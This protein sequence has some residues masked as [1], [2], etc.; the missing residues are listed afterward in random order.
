MAVTDRRAAERS[1]AALSF[2]F[3]VAG[4][5]GM[6]DPRE[7]RFQMTEQ[8]NAEGDREQSGNVIEGARRDA[9]AHPYGILIV[10]DEEAILE[11]LELTLGTD[12]RIFTAT[13]GAQG[14]EVLEREEIALVIA[15]QVMPAMTGVEFLEKV[16]ER[17]PRTIRMMLT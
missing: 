13:T 6:L 10:D 5:T 9:S 4:P 15:D 2:P 3:A 8:R 17:D 11:S 1:S 16:I 7:R 14:L 12:Y